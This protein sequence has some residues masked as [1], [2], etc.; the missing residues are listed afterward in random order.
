MSGRHYR[1]IPFRKDCPR[2]AGG[3]AASCPDWA[4]YEQDRMRRYED[5]RR[6]RESL[7]FSIGEKRGV[8]AFDKAYH[9]GKRR[10]GK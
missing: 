8:A 3:C 7:Q 5:S 9:E 2:R 1:P 6:D 10:Y 4:A